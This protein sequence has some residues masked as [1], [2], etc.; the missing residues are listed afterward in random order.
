MGGLRLGSGIDSVEPDVL[1]G[2]KTGWDVVPRNHRNPFQ[3]DSGD[4]RSLSHSLLGDNAK[5]GVKCVTADNDC[6][7]LFQVEP[8]EFWNEF[9]EGVERESLAVDLDFK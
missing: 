9:Y 8:V 5:E 2:D 4:R 3:T 1:G 6:G 7:T